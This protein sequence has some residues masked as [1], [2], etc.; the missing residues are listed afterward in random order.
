MPSALKALKWTSSLVGLAAFGAYCNDSRASIYPFIVMP[1]LHLLDPEESHN[2]SIKLLKY[3]ISP[4]DTQADNDRLSTSFKGLK[5]SNPI[6]L[7]AGYDKNGEAIDGLFNLGF[8]LVEIGSVTPQPQPGNPLPRFFRL[9]K[10]KAVINRYGF[11]SDGHKVVFDRLMERIQNWMFGNAV[12]VDTRFS[13]R[14][15]RLLGV[16]LGS[17]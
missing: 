16:N 12:D 4:K 14:S 7:A 8:G 15:D 2:L 10:D 6:G 5:I 11:N 17:F 1:A 3:G 13:L 9:E